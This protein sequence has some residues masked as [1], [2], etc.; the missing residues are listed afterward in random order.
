[1]YDKSDAYPNPDDTY[2]STRDSTDASET[3]VGVGSDDGRDELGNAE[4]TE[5]SCGR[6]LHEE[7]SVRTGDEDQS[8]RDDSDLQVDN[9]V[10]LS[11]VGI[12]A[13]SWSIVESN[14]ELVLE[15]RCLHD[16]DD[17]DDTI[18]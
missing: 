8:L 14:T 1:M 18:K 5:K 17:E 4:C 13:S 16:D 3:P 6:T 10:Q 15:E 12:W 2:P 7:E 9:H 11:V